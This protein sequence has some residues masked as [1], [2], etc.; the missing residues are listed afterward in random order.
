MNT[1][2]R[3]T[4]KSFS[5]FVEENYYSCVCFAWPGYILHNRTENNDWKSSRESHSNIYIA[6]VA[7]VQRGGRG[8]AKCEESAKRDR[9]DPRSQRSRFTL[10]SHLRSQRSRFALE[11]N[12]PLPPLFLI[13]T[14]ATQANLYI[15]CRMRIIL[16]KDF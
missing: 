4:R 1:M 12:F 6:C 5:V 13:C 16:P 15:D 10:S 11:F 9:W 2:P 8:K 14:P 3:Y 7:G